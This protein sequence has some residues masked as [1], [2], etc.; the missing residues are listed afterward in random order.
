MGRKNNSDK[1]PIDHFRR[2][3]GDN[4]RRRQKDQLSRLKNIADKKNE[5]RHIAAWVWKVIMVLF[6]VMVISAF[7]IAGMNYYEGLPVNNSMNSSL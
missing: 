7:A 3:I 4:Q 1:I 5:N 2:A 6:G